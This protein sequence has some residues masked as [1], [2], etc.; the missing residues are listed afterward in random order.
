M[1][2]V[3]LDTGFGS[4]KLEVETKHGQVWL[5]VRSELEGNVHIPL[6]HIQA[7]ELCHALVDAANE[8]D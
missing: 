1:E 8:V 5:V 6:N 2:K 3:T 4:I 7:H